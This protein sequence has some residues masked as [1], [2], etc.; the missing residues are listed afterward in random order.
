[1]PVWFRHMLTYPLRLGPP[2]ENWPSS[3]F[4]VLAIVNNL[5]AAGDA[6]VGVALAGSV[7]V[8]VPLNAARDRTALGLVCTVLPFAVVAPL[9]GPFTDRVR[10]GKGFVV[11]L[12]A[13]GRLA[14]VVMMGMW[15]HS[16]LLF[17]AAFV[18]LVCSKT[19]AVARAALVPAV[20]EGE[21]QLVPANSKMAIGGG[22]ASALAAG[23]GA[24]VYALSGSK[25]VLDAD[26][27]VFALVTVLAVELLGPKAPVQ[28]TEPARR[29]GAGRV[30]VVPAAVR[31]AA[32]AIGGVRAMAGF[33]TALVAFGFRAQR[34][35]VVWYGLVAAVG[36]A[37]S[38]AGASLAPSARSHA[39][40][41]IK[42]VASSCL[43]IGLT[44]AVATQS[45]DAQHRLGALGL[46]LVAGLAGA[47]AKT[48]F[49]AMVQSQVPEAARAGSFAR[50]EAMFQTCWV[51]A[52]LLPTLLVIPLTAGFVAMS[53]LLVLLGLILV[54]PVRAAPRHRDR[55]PRRGYPSQQQATSGPT[56]R[57]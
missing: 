6:L 4:G 28:K 24:A 12:A 5:S 37:G 38:L 33:M 32:V 21:A 36:V 2:E 43:L 30:R 29:S 26:I 23:L 14:A 50:L 47:L 18:A 10:W 52:A 54:A 44:A 19:H 9:T 51:L 16:L 56:G 8:S 53:V 31:R 34:A 35:P 49:D 46:A 17:P 3:R 45:P 55:P 27:L 13:A 25:A 42:L 39:G 11:L 48:A 41:N 57:S 7:F 20:V 40:S 22:V 15:V 1:V